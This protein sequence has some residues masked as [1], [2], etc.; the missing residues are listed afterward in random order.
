MTTA[1][2]TK[3]IYEPKGKAREYAALACNIYKGC[4][5]GCRYCF[6]AKT[7]W[8]SADDYYGAANP[9]D[10]FLEKLERQA[11]KMNGG[12]PE[13]LLSFQGDVY[14]PAETNLRFDPGVLL[15]P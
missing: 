7:P 8:V 12:T 5:H 4:E 13:I 14:Q 6:G 3:V 9:K 10:H 11:S 15:Q 1:R 2:N